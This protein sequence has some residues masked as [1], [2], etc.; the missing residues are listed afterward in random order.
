M[1]VVLETWHHKKGVKISCPYDI[2]ILA[3]GGFIPSCSAITTGGPKNGPSYQGAG[4]E[5]AVFARS[6]SRYT[7]GLA[8]T[9]A[10]A[11]ALD[12]KGLQTKI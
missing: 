11:P 6:R 9:P 7:D 12:S 8:P 10:P 2:F 3:V 1:I 5:A 4:V